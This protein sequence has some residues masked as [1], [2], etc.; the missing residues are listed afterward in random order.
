MLPRSLRARLIVGAAIWVSIGMAVSGIV[1]AQLFRAVVTAQFDHDLTDHLDELAALIEIDAD[2]RPTTLHQL[3]D[4]RFLPPRSGL[5]WQARADDVLIRSPSLLGS[6]LPEV[7]NKS[8]KQPVS[9]VAS[10]GAVRVL[11]KTVE[12]VGAS[13]PIQLSVALDERLIAQ[14]MREIHLVLAGSLAVIALGLIAA[15]YAQIE[16]GLQPL[17]R[18]RSTL[19]AVRAGTREELPNDLP[20]EIAPLVSDLNALIAANR[21]MVRR[22]RLQAGKFAHAMKTPLTI[23]MDEGRVLAAAGHLEAAQAVID[24]C[25]QMQ[26][27]I[28][29]QTARARASG[30]ENPGAV[31]KVGPLMR[32]VIAALTQ[33]NRYRSVAFALSGDESVAVACDPQD[34]HEILGNIL[35][36][37]AKWAR[38][39]VTATIRPIG[40]GVRISIEDDGPGIPQEDWERAFVVG[41]RLGATAAGSGLGLAIARDLAVLYG[42]RAWIDRAELGGVAAHVELPKIVAAYPAGQQS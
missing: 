4:A 20:M 32:E 17:A 18:I 39:R 30:R 27:Q 15:A 33:L 2:G 26:L 16:F 6:E 24:Q 19:N 28:D 38:A 29:Y 37:G 9:I 22:A 21:H 25:R 8:T 13:R 35:D 42:G 23:L 41:E 36:N 40:D 1:L 3:S 14:D 7:A 31:T 34:L 11:Q 5:Y 10:I 12:V